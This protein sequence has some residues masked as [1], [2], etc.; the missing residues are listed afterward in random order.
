[1]LKSPA[2]NKA[3]KHEDIS[4]PFADRPLYKQLV[5]ACHKRINEHQAASTYSAHMGLLPNVSRILSNSCCRFALNT[6]AV[7]CACC[8]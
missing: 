5:A 4:C 8:G 6:E 1:M 2:N 7:S 3:G